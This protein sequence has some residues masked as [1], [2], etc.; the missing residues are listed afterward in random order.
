[1][2]IKIRFGLKS[3]LF[4]RLKNIYIQKNPKVFTNIFSLVNGSQLTTISK[5]LFSVGTII[6]NNNIKFQSRETKWIN[7]KANQGSNSKNI[8][9]KVV[10]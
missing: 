1:M 9:R 10:L 6:V 7:K 2:S 5:I 3:K 4:K 8:S